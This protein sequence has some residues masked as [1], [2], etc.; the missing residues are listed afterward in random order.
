M[1]D[2][3]LLFERVERY[4]K[5]RKLDVARESRLG[6]VTDGTVWASVQNS[7]IKAIALDSVYQTERDCYRRLQSHRVES[8]GGFSIPMLRDYD[9][10]LQ[11]VKMEIVS[12]PYLLDFG[13]AY[14]DSPPAYWADAQLRQ[15]AY[16]EW[17]ERFDEDWQ[18]VAGVLAMLTKYGIHYVDPRPSNIHLG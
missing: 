11:V 5:S 10:A 16:E 2:E 8:L 17:R 18:Q 4:A 13:K 14:L 12:P 9:D 15:N 6:Y 7:A 3:S 1:I